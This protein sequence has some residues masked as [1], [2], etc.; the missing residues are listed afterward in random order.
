M[1][2][3]ENY[4]HNISQRIDPNNSN[5]ITKLINTKFDRIPFSQLFNQYCLPHSPKTLD[6]L[7]SGPDASEP[8]LN[9]LFLNHVDPVLQKLKRPIFITDYPS[10]ISPLAALKKDR[11]NFV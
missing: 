6:Q 11:N 3:T 8:D 9:Q 5:R 10:F 2:I 7:I 1:D 4:I